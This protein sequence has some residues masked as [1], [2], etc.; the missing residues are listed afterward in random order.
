MG[1]EGD[2]TSS[3]KT[4]VLVVCD[5]DVRFFARGVFRRPVR[6][7]ARCV[8]CVHCHGLEAVL[9]KLVVV[10]LVTEG[11]DGRTVFVVHGAGRALVPAVEGGKGESAVYY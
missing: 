11:N 3:V 9:H 10:V 7:C 4:D 1:L 6:L 2:V 5:Q 8:L